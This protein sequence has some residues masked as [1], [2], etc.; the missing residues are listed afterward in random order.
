M[1][2]MADEKKKPSGDGKSDETKDKQK[3]E[4]KEPAENVKNKMASRP[5]WE[6]LDGSKRR[7]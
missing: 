3:E 6:S 2:V 1:K 7:K 5:I 4:K